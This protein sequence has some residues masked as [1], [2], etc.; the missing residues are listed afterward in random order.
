M[1]LSRVFSVVS[2]VCA[3]VAFVGSIYFFVFT[4]G[5][6]G[7]L[8]ATQVTGAIGKAQ[9]NGGQYDLIKNR[10]TVVGL[11]CWGGLAQ[12]CQSMIDRA[13]KNSDLKSAFLKA[14]SSGVRIFV[15][16]EFT[17]GDGWVNIDSGSNDQTIIRF[18][19]TN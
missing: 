3:L 18:L 12:A 11:E 4:H 5:L 14:K 1:A 2:I 15:V 10:A 6:Q 19:L 7:S 16:G 17:V 9:I 13:M 8:K